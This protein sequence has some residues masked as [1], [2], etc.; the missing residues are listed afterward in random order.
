MYLE[1]DPRLDAFVLVVGGGPDGLADYTGQTL[2]VDEEARAQ[3]MIEQED[4]EWEKR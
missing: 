2:G 3:R 4:W 1:Y